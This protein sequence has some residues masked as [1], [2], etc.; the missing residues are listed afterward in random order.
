AFVFSAPAQADKPRELDGTWIE[1]IAEKDK[2]APFDPV[3]L[4]I[5][6][7]IL[8][9]KYGG[10]VMRQSLIRFVRDQQPLAIDLFSVE[11]GELWTNL[12][13]YKTKQELLT[14]SESPRDQN[15]PPAFHPARATEA[16]YPPG[17]RSK[18]AMAADQS[19][20]ASGWKEGAQTPAV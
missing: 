8:V 18:G 15:R 9:E 5:Q 11:A 20:P 3:L 17:R 10:Q 14:I 7:N 1:I 2:N 19:S 13:T 12:P 6:R 4:I 16:T